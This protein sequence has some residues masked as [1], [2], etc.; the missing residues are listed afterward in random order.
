MITYTSNTPRVV[1]KIIDDF[2][3]ALSSIMERGFFYKRSIATWDTEVGKQYNLISD[4]TLRLINRTI[5]RQLKRPFVRAVYYEWYD[6]KR[7][8]SGNVI[9][10]PGEKYKYVRDPE[11][12]G[13]AS[14]TVPRRRYLS[15]IINPLMLASSGDGPVKH[16]M[17]TRDIYFDF[18]NP[19]GIAVFN[20]FIEQMSTREEMRTALKL[21]AL[22]EE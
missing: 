21:P 3:E 18:R 19:E 11:A 8:A 22:P 12:R 5:A 6:Y 15:P 13:A 17:N 4:P 14:I 20:D 9:P 7:D 16:W 10:L 1:G 2:N